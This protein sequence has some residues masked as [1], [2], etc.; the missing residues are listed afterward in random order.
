[1]PTASPLFDAV[2]GSS[3]K[4]ALELLTLARRIGSP[5]AVVFGPDAERAVETL[6][7]HGAEHVYLAKDQRMLDYLVVPMV[8]ALEQITRQIGADLATV[9][10][11]MLVAVSVAA[12]VVA[13]STLLTPRKAGP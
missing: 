9:S 6:A 12:V 4:P 10:L 5:S 7:S 3:P 1:M 8:D 2:D 11:V 13:A